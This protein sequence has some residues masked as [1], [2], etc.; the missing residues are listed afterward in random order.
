[1]T[2]SVLEGEPLLIFLAGPN[3]AGKTTFFRAYLAPLG[4]P[5]VNA[6]VVARSLRE[7][8]PARPAREIDA[9]A[10][11]SAE[12]WRRELLE[13]GVSFCTETVFSD[14]EGA[15]LQFLRDAGSAGYTVFLVFVGISDSQLSMARV[16]ER[17]AAGGHDVPDD[18]LVERFPRTLANL[19]T[20]IPLADEAY[21][22]DNSSDVEPFRLVA[23]YRDGLVTQQ[24]E[25]LPAWAAGLPGL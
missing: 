15:K 13:S 22:F 9:A 24:A 18:K 6:D 5:F 19:R 23:V 12:K 20:A 3:G 16:M 7:A 8:S 17:V 10:F 14:P 21:V 25:V 2:G 1:L 11:A 4:L